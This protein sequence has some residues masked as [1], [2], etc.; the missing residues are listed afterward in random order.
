MNIRA[1]RRMGGSVGTIKQFTIGEGVIIGSILG[2]AMGN[3]LPLR[4]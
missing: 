1:V 4:M 3:V 2:G